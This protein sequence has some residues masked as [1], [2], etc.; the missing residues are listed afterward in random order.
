MQRLLVSGVALLALGG[1]AS[2][3]EL[4][5][6]ITYIAPDE[7]VFVVDNGNRFTLGPGL[8][9]A[10]LQ[11]GARVEVTYEGEGELMTASAVDIL[12]VPGAE[13]PVAGAVA[14]AVP[15]APAPAAPA[16]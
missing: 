4:T 2:A 1:A 6:Y 15:A 16:P 8:D 7:N 11:F 5:G 13:A 10:T 3:A 14:P 12:P 9:K